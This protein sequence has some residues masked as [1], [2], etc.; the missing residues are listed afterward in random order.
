MGCAAGHSPGIYSCEADDFGNEKS[1]ADAVSASQRGCGAATKSVHTR[2]GS[3]VCWVLC[4][5]KFPLERDQ[6]KLLTKL[7][8]NYGLNAAVVDVREVN[9][10]LD[11]AEFENKD[12]IYDVGRII[13]EEVHLGLITKLLCTTRKHLAT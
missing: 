1:D 9:K 7:L 4:S 2:L 11:S 5:C 13:V 8:E 6:V 10:A 3:L 12:P